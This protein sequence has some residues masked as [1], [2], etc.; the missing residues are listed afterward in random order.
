MTGVVTDIT[1]AVLPSAKVTATNIA[2]GAKTSE[3]YE[4]RQHRILNVD[5]GTYTV[6]AEVTDFQLR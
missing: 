5:A 6:S 3:T 4:K 2:M 1:G